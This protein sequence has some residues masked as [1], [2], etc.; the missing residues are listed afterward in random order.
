M[1]EATNPDTRTAP[2]PTESA[3]LGG[4]VLRAAAT[5]SGAA[6][7]FEHDGA[8]RETSYSELGEP[9]ARSPAG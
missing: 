8:W 3:G 9:S 1:S 7:R 6:L 5:R 4:M 2:A